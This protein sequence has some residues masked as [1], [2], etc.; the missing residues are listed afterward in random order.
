MR[1]ET[2]QRQLIENVRSDSIAVE[3][4]ANGAFK[5]SL[6]VYVD[7]RSAKDCQAASDWLI[8]QYKAL[9]LIFPSKARAA[10][11]EEKYLRGQVAEL[12]AKANGPDGK[13]EIAIQ[14]PADEDK[15]RTP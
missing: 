11:D 10:S 15:T 3:E 4:L 7:S 13:R 12:E 6:K 9:N 2:I 14:R 1:T 8:N 5:K